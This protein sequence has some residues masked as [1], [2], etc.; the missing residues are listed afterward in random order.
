MLTSISCWQ[1]LHLAVAGLLLI[2]IEQL[3]EKWMTRSLKSRN[4]Q[5]GLSSP[6][7]SLPGYQTKRMTTASPGRSTPRNRWT[8]TPIYPRHAALLWKVRRERR[9]FR[10]LRRRTLHG[11]IQRTKHVQYLIKRLAEE[12][13]RFEKYLDE[14]EEALS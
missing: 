11:L 14:Q 5:P 13:K 8:P 6:N 3:I 7:L 12:R 9:P 1:L 4:H 2:A 10:P